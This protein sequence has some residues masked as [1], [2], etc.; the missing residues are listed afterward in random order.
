MNTLSQTLPGRI[1][2]L[3]WLAA[4]RRAWLTI[5]SNA[6]ARAFVATPAGT[7]AVVAGFVALLVLGAQIG[8]QIST[9]ALALIAATLAAIAA[10]P[11]QRLAII[12][13][14][15][16][17]YM[18]AR[19][20]RIA[21]WYDL[22]RDMAQ[23]ILPGISPQIIVSFASATFLA[24]VF[25]VLTLMRA[26]PAS[27]AARRPVLALIAGWFGLLAAA[28]LSP[29]Q[30]P[31][32][33]FL[34]TLTG[35]S[36]SALWF[37]AYAA[38]DMKGKDTTPIA[39]RASFMRPFWG[40]SALP[41]GKSFG[42][43]NR[44]DAKDADELAVTRLK[45]LKLAVWALILAALWKAVDQL[46]Y[47]AGPLV[48]I[49]DAIVAHAGG[50][51]L[52][53]AHNWAVTLANYFVDLLVISVWGHFIVATIRMCG[54]R[55]PRNTV[56]PLASRSLA[57]FW[58]RYFFYF[59]E[60]LVDFFFYPAFLR[61]FKTHTKLRIAFATF[62]AAGLGNFLYHFMRETHVFATLPVADALT[63]FQ[64]AVFYSLALALGLIVSQWRGRKPAPEDGF[65]AYHVWP[66][67]NVIAF[68][69]FLKI[70][71]DITGEGTLVE[72]AAFTLSLFGVQ[73]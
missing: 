43:L 2:P 12:A 47:Q 63:V 67:L 4:K 48:S 40:G 61:Y 34:W 18:I 71:D 51:S 70:F 69:C 32:H 9:L 16:A 29:P 41:I 14:A 37:F 23:G 24:M 3:A 42:Y 68:F 15:S 1:A 46:F 66:R 6:R 11:A 56:N 5:D 36:I 25:V 19:P 49:Q 45:A 28:L 52:G 17:A 39:V 13:A 26:F 60:L 54:W 8:G 33:A 53:T 55:I 20:F 21:P 7:A 44:F 35:V 65:L 57:E 58:N 72:R 31:L 27:F 38:V 64:N 50:V 22:S 30:T 59:K 10:F 62:C 73:T